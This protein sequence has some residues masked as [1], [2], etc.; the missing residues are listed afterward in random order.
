M[1]VIVRGKNVEVTEALR[2]YAVRKLNRLAKHF[3]HHPLTAT[4]V[5]AVEK[6]RQIVE[7]TIPLEG[8]R[9]LR[10]EE[11]T[12]DMYASIDLVVDKLDRQLDHYKTRLKRRHE[13]DKVTAAPTAP[14]TP[15]APV[16]RRKSFPVKP[17]TLDE[18]ILQM[19]LLGHDFF[20]FRDA[21]REAI[22]ILYRRRDGNLGLLEPR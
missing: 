19:E 5:L 22:S 9:I 11:A 13:P 8:G 7:V 4:V 1:D 20:A 18:A 10:G 16:V 17:M 15:S 6:A 21:E 14:L 2:E 12:D 3:D